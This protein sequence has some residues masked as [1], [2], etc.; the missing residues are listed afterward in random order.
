M[1][2]RLRVLL[3]LAVLGLGIAGTVA[4]IAAR[5]EAEKRPAEVLAPLVRTLEVKTRDLELSITAWG[6]VV[7][8]TESSL[9]PEISGPVVWISPSL[10]AGGFFEAGDVLLRVDPRDYEA[11][12]ER[13][14]AS[15]ERAKSELL[16]ATRDLERRRELARR[17]FASTAALDT[18]ENAERVARA[19]LR[20]ARA[21]LSQADRDLERTELRAPFAGRVREKRVDVG[22]FLARGVS[23][24]TLYAVDFAEVKLPVPD[25][26]LAFL[27]IPLG[28]RGENGGVASGPEVHLH[29]RFAGGQHVWTGRVVRT[30]GE[31][32]PKSRMLNVIA[33]VE[34]PYGRGED[35]ERPPLSVGMFVRAEIRGRQVRDVAVVPR[36]A[37]RE[38]DSVLVVDAESRIRFRPVSVLRADRTEVVI[39]TGLASGERVVVSPLEAPVDG[40]RVRISGTDASETTS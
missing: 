7:P 9:I 17:D 39:R 21:V 25:A 26:E 4:L 15:V 36:A 3:P 40:M 18:A 37:L 33:Q 6:T 38:G 27:D 23:V 22:Q 11:A 12:L 30:E 16:R 31:L 13:A 20:E 28:Y 32:D 19:A 1:S 10:A 29:A 5:P 14:R 35:P 24:A 2:R 8:R 34:N